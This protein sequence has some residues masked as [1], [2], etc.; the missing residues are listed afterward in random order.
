MC[1][2]MHSKLVTILVVSTLLVG[3][4]TIKETYKPRHLGNLA[5]QRVAGGIELRLTPDKY[6]ARIG[7]PLTIKVSIRNVSDKPILLPSE[8]D[9]LLAW[10]YPDGKRD[11]LVRS[12]RVPPPNYIALAPGEERISQ[13]VVT[14][15]Y[16]DRGGIH[17]FRAILNGDKH[18]KSSDRAAWKGRAISNG[19]GVLF[20]EK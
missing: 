3:C 12:E 11:N 2:M 1:E 5:D 13:S 14:T 10:V 9:L 4:G 8:P 6:R 15:Q 20:V 16:F 7:D 19:Y 18:A 17:E